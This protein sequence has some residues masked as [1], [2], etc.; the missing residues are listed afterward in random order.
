MGKRLVSEGGKASRYMVIYV[1]SRTHV[2][3]GLLSVTSKS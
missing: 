3:I 2:G 1:V